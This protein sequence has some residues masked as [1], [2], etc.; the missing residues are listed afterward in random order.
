MDP[1][2]TIDH[3]TFDPVDIILLRPLKA[4]L[5]A[6]IT[7]VKRVGVKTNFD[8]RYRTPFMEIKFEM[9]PPED[10]AGSNLDYGTS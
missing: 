2:Y 1:A 6:P 4:L 5:E 9:S 7:A 10:R 8:H 3:A